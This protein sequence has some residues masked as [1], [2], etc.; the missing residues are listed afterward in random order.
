MLVLVF[1]KVWITSCRLF[2]HLPGPRRLVFTQEEKGMDQ[3]RDLSVSP[4]FAT[5]QLC[6]SGQHFSVD[7]SFHLNRSRKG[8][9]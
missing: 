4:G 3:S 5:D 2:I 8:P 9:F 6:D 1:V 7:L